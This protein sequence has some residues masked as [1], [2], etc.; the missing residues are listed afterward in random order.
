MAADIQIGSGSAPTLSTDTVDATN[1]VDVWLSYELTNAGDQEGTAVNYYVTVDGPN[2]AVES[3]EFVEDQTIAAGA[4]TQVGA[5][6]SAQAIGQLQPGD[7]WVS[8]RD[9]DGNTLGGA[10]L[11]VTGAGG[12]PRTQA[13][14]SMSLSTDQVSVASP[15]QVIFSYELWNDGNADDTSTGFYMTLE[16]GNG[17]IITSDYAPDAA[18]PAGQTIQ[19]GIT[20]EEGTI[21]GLAAGQYMVNL[22]D[23]SGAV[24]GG[25]GLSVSQ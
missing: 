6:V 4:T 20:I 21:Q 5:R 1:P 9:S 16:D 13:G 11:T 14:G 2:N 17:T 24:L 10:R 3:S 25:V 15:V 18:V 12:A 19:Q 8:L 23:P 7:Y 22:R